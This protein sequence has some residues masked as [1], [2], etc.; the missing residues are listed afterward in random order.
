[1][2][3]WMHA[4]AERAAG[5]QRAPTRPLMR[6]IVRY[7]QQF[8]VKLHH[9]KEEEHLFRRL[10]ERTTSCHAEL[11]ELARQHDRD[12]QLVEALAQQVETLPRPMPPAP[13]RATRAL[14]EQVAQLRPLPVG[15]HGP[16]GRRDPAG[17]AAPPAG[18]GLG[19]DRRRLCREPR[20]ELRRQ[21]RQGI[22]PAVLAHR[23]P[24]AGLNRRHGRRGGASP[25]V[26][27]GPR[28]DCGRSH[29]GTIGDDRRSQHGYATLDAE[30][31]RCSSQ[32][33]AP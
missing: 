13:L 2:H 1:M 30:V 22:P 15:P 5:G 18:R 9:P 10:R 7:V 33:S 20:P 26:R 19:V 29:S 8:P 6:A 14:E 27:R 12:E 4:L 3:A 16:R 28:S 25:A 21:H 31:G 24:A 11:D 17:G 32:G 23:Q